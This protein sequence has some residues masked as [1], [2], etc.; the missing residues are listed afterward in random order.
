MNIKNMFRKL[1]NRGPVT[2]SLAVILSVLFVTGLVNAATTI[3]ENIVT[4][5][6]LQVDGISTL[7]GA[8]AITTANVTTLKVGT[9]GIS[10]T[11][12]ISGTCN[13]KV[14]VSITAT[15]TEFGYCS[16]IT[17]LTSS[18]R[19]FISLST[20]T[21]EIA[22]QFVPV[23]VQASTTASGSFDVKLLNLTGKTAVPAAT[24]GFGSTTQYWILH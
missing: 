21:T 24:V 6:S 11:Q 16:G 18:D 5:G 17:G 3:S 10:H 22:N 12:M 20:T 13:L 1:L 7:S 14:N 19:V 2:V 8:A 4:A 9:N 23:A 15:S